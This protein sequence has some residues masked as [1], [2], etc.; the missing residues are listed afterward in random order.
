MNSPFPNRRHLLAGVLVTSL[1][2]STAASARLDRNAAAEQFVLTE[3]QK[4]LT[5]S[6]NRAL[7]N[8]ARSAAFGQLI[9]QLADFQR[10]SGFVLGRYARQVTP[11]QRQRFN[12]AFRGYA[13]KLFQSYLAGFRG[14]QLRVTGSFVRGPTDTVVNT[15]VS[16]DAEAGPLPVAWRI[17]GTPG[18][19]RAVDVQARGV[20][21][22]ITLQQDFVSTIDT[23][24]GDVNVLITRLESGGGL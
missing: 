3:G 22:A 20:W 24:G 8:A 9:D 1:A 15:V 2:P 6:S 23:A 12:A 13:R 10:I 5:I 19:F 16:G 18:S 21:L 7:S 11:V 4:A 17:V 14:N